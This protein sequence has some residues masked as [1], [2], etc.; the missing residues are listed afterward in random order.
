MP[1]IPAIFA[2]PTIVR[3]RAMGG[4]VHVSAFEH[5]LDTSGRYTTED[6][7]PYQYTSHWSWIYFFNNE[8]EEDGVT[9]WEW[10]AS[11]SR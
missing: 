7:A 8:C 4:D 5:V 1:V 2:I 9:I 10:L 11:Q 3:L 6:G